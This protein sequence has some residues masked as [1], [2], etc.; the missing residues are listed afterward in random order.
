MLQFA[1]GYQAGIHY[2]KKLCV[3]KNLSIVTLN[4]FLRVLSTSH[5]HKKWQK[6]RIWDFYQKMDL[7]ISR[8]FVHKFL[9]DIINSKGDIVNTFSWSLIPFKKEMLK[10]IFWVRMFRIIYV[11]KILMLPQWLCKLSKICYSVSSQSMKNNEVAI[12]VTF[13]FLVYKRIWTYLFQ[14]IYRFSGD[15]F[16]Y[17][18][19]FFSSHLIF[20]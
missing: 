4:Y 14:S 2:L 12:F 19:L 17:I 9:D 7:Y 18:Q 8:I 15:Y 6:F 16:T 13:D 10:L 1:L 5:F 20:V 11:I 3:F